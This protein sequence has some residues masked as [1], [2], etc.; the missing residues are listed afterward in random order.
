MHF[1]EVVSASA[2]VAASSARLAK[3]GRFAELFR[4]LAPGEIAPVVAWVSGE[5]RQG[6][7]G[8][9]YST[10]SSVAGVRAADAPALTIADVDA[11]LTALA[12]V[13]GSG[14][15]RAR[16]QLLTTLFT[17]ATHDEQDF[18]RRLLYGELRQ[19]ALEGVVIEAVAKAAGIAGRRD[20]VAPC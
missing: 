4:S 1:A 16:G 10:I 9:G 11:T 6:R 15:A 18:L 14:S 13:S 19:G 20:C 7:M 3:I 5:P 8:L 2:A 12:A 17:R